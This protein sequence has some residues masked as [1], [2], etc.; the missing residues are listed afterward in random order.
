MADQVVVEGEETAEDLFQ[1]GR[2]GTGALPS[3]PA[4]VAAGGGNNGMVVVPGAHSV[5]DAQ[6]EA[7]SLG[8]EFSSSSTTTTSLTVVDSQ[9]LMLQLHEDASLSPLSPKELE[10]GSVSV[11]DPDFSMFKIKKGPNSVLGTGS[12]IASAS[13]HE[14]SSSDFESDSG[15]ENSHAEV[16]SPEVGGASSLSLATKPRKRGVEHYLKTLPHDDLAVMTNGDGGV[17]GVATADQSD[18]GEQSCDTIRIDSFIK[19]LDDKVLF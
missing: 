1:V 16:P 11:L 12:S 3:Y 13:D 15:I 8:R 2:G 4:P 9:E 17:V 6:L 10:N 19:C 7:L 18:S 14:V 5:L